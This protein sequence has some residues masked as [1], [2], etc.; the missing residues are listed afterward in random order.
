[1]QTPLVTGEHLYV[2]RDNGSL[3]CYEAKTGRRLYQERL[4]SGRDGF[5]AS[6]VAGDGKLYYTGEPGKVYVVQAG[7][8]FKLLAT[9]SMGEACM[10]TP[11]LSEGTLFFRTQGHVV[12]VSDKAGR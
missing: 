10:A 3:A 4:G 8:E 6:A 9:N 5:T 11:A 2:C 1:M 7:P 12:A